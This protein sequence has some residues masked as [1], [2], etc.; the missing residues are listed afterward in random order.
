MPFSI[1]SSTLFAI[2]ALQFLNSRGP[3][4]CTPQMEPI[5]AATVWEITT[6]FYAFSHIPPNQRFALCMF[7]LQPRG[8]GANCVH[9]R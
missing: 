4:A 3:I 1:Y 6:S 5:R 9:Y 8:C 7:L 2:R